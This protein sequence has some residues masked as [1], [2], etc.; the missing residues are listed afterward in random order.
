MLVKDASFWG[1][2][3]IQIGFMAAKPNN[4]VFM[5]AIN[6]IV[7]NVDKKYYGKTPLGVTGPKLFYDIL[8]NNNYNIYIKNIKIKFDGNGKTGCYLDIKTNKKL[9]KYKSLKR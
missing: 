8:D 5:D 2:N 6:Q 7:A 1:F 3:G 4:K 9:I